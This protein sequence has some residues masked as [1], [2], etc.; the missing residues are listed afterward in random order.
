MF[1]TTK[2]SV[3]DTT[4][5]SSLGGNFYDATLGVYVRSAP[6]TLVV[7]LS[8]DWHGTTL[9]NI[10]PRDAEKIMIQA[11]ISIV[12]SSRINTIFQQFKEGLL[13]E[14]E[15]LKEVKEAV[16]QDEGW[17]EEVVGDL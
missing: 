14:K 6:G 1:L 16:E 2:R 10:E 3:P 9:L 5:D 4:T 8:T 17:H 13:T 15:V 11:G 7:F 12:T